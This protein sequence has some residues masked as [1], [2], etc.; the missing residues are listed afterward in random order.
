MSSPALIDAQFDRAVEIVQGLPKTGPIQTDYEEKLTIL[1]KQATVG[2]VTS[3]RPGIWD[4]LGRAK[5][6]AWA[7]HKDLDPYEAK[8]LYVEA[9]LKVLRKYSDKTIAKNLVQELESYNGDPSHI[10]MSHSTLSRSPDS[11]GSSSS[12]EDGQASSFVHASQLQ[13]LQQQRLSRPQDAVSSSEEDNSEGD[14]EPHELP[15]SSIPPIH[16]SQSS[17]SSQH[18][19]RTP[20]TGSMAMTSPGPHPTNLQAAHGIPTMQPHPGYE[21]PSAF[22]EPS[23][24][25]I[26]SSLYPG[27]SSYANFSRAELVSPEAS[28]AAGL[29]SGR[30]FTQPQPSLP[31]MGQYGVVRPASTIAMQRALESMQSQLVAVTERLEMLESVVPHASGRLGRSPGG[32]NTPSWNG[33]GGPD[34]RRPEWDLDDMGMWSVVLNPLARAFERLREL[35]KFFAKNENRSPSM[36]VIRRLC[37]DVSFWLFSVCFVRLIWKKSR[38]RRREVNTALAL[39]WRALLGRKERTLVDRGV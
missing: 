35:A 2:N 24:T 21:T 39:L 32:S 9:L 18:R 17:L 38:E 5:W 23:P 29:Y 37:L 22:V 25:S 30:P 4:M 14:D 12:E 26:P 27:E 33:Q 10:I 36:I 1:Y 3:P 8:W 15:R 11:S 28:S 16:R 31:P 34:N 19:Y 6:D 7:K 20:M 13:S